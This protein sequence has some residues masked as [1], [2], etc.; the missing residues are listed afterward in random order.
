MVDILRVRML[1]MGA[2]VLGAGVNRGAEGD[3]QGS[4]LNRGG[5]YES[6]LEQGC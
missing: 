6:G 2:G 1:N 3:A 5:G 4:V